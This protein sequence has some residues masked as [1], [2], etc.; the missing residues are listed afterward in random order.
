MSR[1]GGQ[2]GDALINAEN[3]TINASDELADRFFGQ[4][5]VILSPR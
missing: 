5:Q 1:E 4:R 3:A 2:R